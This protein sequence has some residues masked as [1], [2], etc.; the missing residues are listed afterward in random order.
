VERVRGRI[1]GVILNDV[2][3]RDYAQQYYYSYHTYEYGSAE[4]EQRTG[5]AQVES[6]N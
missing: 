3:L 1:T 6:W 2:N 4:R 5:G